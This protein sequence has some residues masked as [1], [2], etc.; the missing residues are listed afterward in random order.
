M[1][2]MMCATACNEFYTTPM[3]LLLL[4]DDH[5]LFR[6][7]L[8]QTLTQ[9]ALV[10]APQCVECEDLAAVQA[11]LEAGLEPDLILLDLHMP[12]TLGF[13][14]LASLRGC[15]PEIPVAIVSGDDSYQRV[16]RAEQLGASGFISKS[17]AP[18]ELELAI[19]RLLAGDVWFEKTDGEINDDVEDVAERIAS[20]TPHQ[21]RVFSLI[22]EG[23][24][25]KQ[26]AF[27]MSIAEPTVKSHVTAIMRKLG[28]RKRTEVILLAQKLA[29]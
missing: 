21:F 26:I 5:P 10:D 4:A 22:C 11:Q 24:L 18:A 15:Y 14:G 16:M 8:K 13:A 28:V 9:S 7:A 19:S 25:N 20:L 23:R 6:T 27:E 2:V 29:S 1:S 3:P 17:L 12:G